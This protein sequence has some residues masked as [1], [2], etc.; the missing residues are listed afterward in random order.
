VALPWK[1]SSD[2]VGARINRDLGQV[3]ITRWKPRQLQLS[4]LCEGPS[5]IKVSQLYFP[6]WTAKLNGRILPLGPSDPE[7][8]IEIEVPA[9]GGS[10]N[11]TLEALWPERWGDRI[12]VA[13]G[14]IW[15]TLIGCLTVRKFRD[16]SARSSAIK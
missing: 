16:A 3:K 5:L 9:G 12:G 10:I 11:V 8:L 2:L 4:Y 6:G 15:L 1:S 7:G 13:S 14:L